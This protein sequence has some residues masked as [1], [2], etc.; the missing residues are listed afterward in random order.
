MHDAGG[1]VEEDPALELCDIKRGLHHKGLWRP[2]WVHSCTI[3]IVFLKQW[4]L[5]YLWLN[6]ASAQR[7]CSPTTSTRVQK[8]CTADTSTTQQQTRT[9]PRESG[10]SFRY[11]PFLCYVEIDPVPRRL[12]PRVLHTFTLFCFFYSS[13]NI[14]A[15]SCACSLSLFLT[16]VSNVACVRCFFI[17]DLSPEQNV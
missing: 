12:G 6:I 11:P 14:T 2:L 17:P 10:V 15:I 13:G 4:I 1:H 16:V 3:F 8:P 5:S 7:W 9:S